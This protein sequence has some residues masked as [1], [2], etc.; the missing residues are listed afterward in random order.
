M[1]GFKNQG[2]AKEKLENI[3]DEQ[4]SL[5]FDEENWI[6]KDL[7]KIAEVTYSYDEE[8]KINTTLFVKG[9]GLD[10]E[11]YKK[12]NK[13][14]RKKL[15]TEAQDNLVKLLNE[16]KAQIQ[17]ALQELELVDI[18]SQN[19]IET[20][21]KSI[22]INS[23]TEK[24][25]LLDYCLNA[26]HFEIEK[27][28]FDLGL[29]KE[30]EEQIEKQQE[31]LD[32]K[33]FGGKIKD[34]PNETI[35]S[36][37]YIFEIYSKNIEKLDT[38]EQ[39]RF[40]GYLEQINQYLPVGYKYESKEKPKQ[41][42]GEF[43]D[44]DIPRK[45]YMLAFNLLVESLEKL[46]HIVESNEGT[47]SISDGP[48]G[49]QFP[50]TDKFDYI[51]ILRFF[52][53]GNHEI[54]THNITDY[55]GKQVIG[56]LRGANSTEK[57]EGV[58][59]LMEQLFTYGNELYKVDKNGDTIIDI[60]KIEISPNFIKILM[61][62]LLDNNELLDFLELSEKIDSDIIS[63]TD[64]YIRLKRNN[65]AGVQH[66]DTTYTRGLF[67]AIDEINKYIKSKGKKGIG[68]EDLF[69]GKIS[70]KETQKLKNIK[71]AKE[72]KSLDEI[73]K[74]DEDSQENIKILKP[75]FI[76]DAVYFI[77]GEKLKGEKGN[78]NSIEFYKYLQKKYPIFNF[79]LEEIENISFKTKRN[80]YGIVNILLKTIGRQQISNITQENKKTVKNLI[81]IVGE[82]YNPKIRFVKRKL[83][84]SRRNAK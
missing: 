18:L 19:S 61:G 62:E 4:N 71:E 7:W 53:L 48:K 69:L 33:L 8:T 11:L 60:D 67:K 68:P 6:D 77:V 12:S 58:A 25:D 74:T 42:D 24:N 50:T 63:P 82:Q 45:D 59:I 36:Y 26:I 5:I 83:H 40:E 76:S 70:F 57:D 51:K 29:L 10:L 80:V 15:L 49:V 73:D 20:D 52:K 30:E 14:E 75:L 81:N 79:T 31:E 64:R 66:K 17:N 43:L 55:N 3:I 35:L 1:V 9:G 22:F 65:K 34:N 46:E 84:P 16:K 39:K 38:E 56:N 37:E 21:I 72:K 13:E 54:E 44:Y 27:A 47:G 41:I 28:G 32:S 23:L 2:S 78:I